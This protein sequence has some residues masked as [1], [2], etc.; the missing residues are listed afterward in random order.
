MMASVACPTYSPRLSGG[1]GDATRVDPRGEFRHARGIQ[2]QL[3]AEKRI[4][5][6]GAS[7]LAG[8]RQ[9]DGEDEH[10][11]GIVFEHFAA[12]HHDLGTLRHDARHGPSVA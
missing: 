11:R 8:D 12:E 6:A 4:P 2:V 10:A 7:H 9:I 5:P 3:E 1:L